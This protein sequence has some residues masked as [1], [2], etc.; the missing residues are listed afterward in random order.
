MLWRSPSS[1]CR[2]FYHATWDLLLLLWCLIEHWMCGRPKLWFILIFYLGP[3]KWISNCADFMVTELWLRQS[4]VFYSKQLVFPETVALFLQ[5]NTRSS[6][7]AP[8][9][10]LQVQKPPFTFTLCDSG[11]DGD[12]INEPSGKVPLVRWWWTFVVW[13]SLTAPPPVFV[14]EDAWCVM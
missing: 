5:G 9:Y 7:A 4:T 1:L 3:N 11:A 2:L 8:I 12:V 6:T 13:H 10:I 14:Q